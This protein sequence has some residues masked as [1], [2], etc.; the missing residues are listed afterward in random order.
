MA[1]PARNYLYKNLVGTQVATFAT[2]VGT[3]HSIVVNATNNQPI[4][5]IDGLT[6]TTAIIG[7]LKASVAEGTYLY[8]CCFSTGLRINVQG[9][10]D[11]TVNFNVGS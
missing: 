5:I 8:D 9:G 11:I 2:G 10:S 7:T 3:L 4:S 6:A 1:G